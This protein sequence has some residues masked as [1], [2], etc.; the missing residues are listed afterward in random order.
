MYYPMLYH[1]T[2]I[3]SGFS[4]IRNKMK[5]TIISALIK[6][7]VYQNVF[8]RTISKGVNEI[9]P[10]FRRHDLFLKDLKTELEN[11]CTLLHI[12][13]KEQDTRQQQKPCNFPMY[14]P[15]TL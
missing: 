6:Y 9:I 12:F 4:K 8:A 3:E 13:K 1:L 7:S 15:R 14:Q 10:L 5:E 2:E 11:F